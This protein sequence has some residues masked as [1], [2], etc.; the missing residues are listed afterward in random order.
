M[1]TR[2]DARARAGALAL[3]GTLLLAGCAGGDTRPGAAP[4]RSTAPTVGGAAGQLEQ[5]YE[6]VVADV[7]PSV[8]EIQTDGG[9]GSGVVYDDRGHIVTNAHVVMGAREIE[10][11]AAN[12]GRPLRAELVGAFAADDLAVVRVS[13][14]S[15]RPAR[16]GDSGDLKVG[17][18]V[19]AMGNPLGLSSSVTNG[20]VSA[21]NRTVSTKREGAFPGATIGNSIQTSAAINPGNSGGALVTLNGE[22]V[23]IPTAAASDPQM[24]GAAPGIGFATP[25]N[26]VKAIAPQ[27][28]QNGRVTN[29]GRAALGVTIR[30][31][32]DPST[33]QPAGLGVVEVTRGGPADKAGIRPDDVIVAVNGTP[34]PTQTALAE[35]LV[36]L[37]PGATAKVEVQ[38][39]G[40]GR[41]TVDVTLGELP[42]S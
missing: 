18:I 41:R 36:Q 15:L 31:V 2:I 20:I 23:G 11:R 39:P 10:V 13:G 34:T 16:F 19:L 22:V 33:Y 29:S 14:A 4:S 9:E 27:L 7:L 1:H 26:T 37:K 8:V 32:V 6:K 12:G 25:S 3:A 38:T 40:A 35:V 5:Q 17:Q 21:L 30:T 28:I 24:G 42:A